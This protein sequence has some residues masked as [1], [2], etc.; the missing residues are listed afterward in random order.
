LSPDQRG[1][2]AELARL[3][4]EIREDREAMTRCLSDIE[5]AAASLSTSPTDRAQ[6]AFAAVALHGWYT[7]LE[8]IIERI[9]RTI[10]RSVPTGDTWHR[11]LLSQSMA[12]IPGLRPAVLPATLK[13]DLVEL[14]D[15]RHFFR[16]AYGVNLDPARLRVNIERLA[17]TAPA[18]TAALDVFERHL[19]ATLALLAGSER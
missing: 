8:T 2:A 4:A 1:A 18:V 15:F 14:L 11:D 9:A 10:D 3:R 12:E 13:R 6:Q 19:D 16:H 17:A 5:A 7:G